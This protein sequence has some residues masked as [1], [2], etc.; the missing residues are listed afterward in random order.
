[1]SLA[2]TRIRAPSLLIN[3]D[4]EE[5]VDCARLPSD[6]W[7]QFGTMA[8]KASWDGYLAEC[9]VSPQLSKTLERVEP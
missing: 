9:V 1:M 6:R 4:W 2:P 8:P 5:R 3:Q 7:E